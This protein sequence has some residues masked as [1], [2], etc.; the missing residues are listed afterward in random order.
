MFSTFVGSVTPDY[1]IT[2]LILLTV[3]LVLQMKLSEHLHQFNYLLLCLIISWALS[4]KLT[5]IL[6]LPLLIVDFNMHFRD[7]R[8]LFTGAGIFL[9]YL[10]PWIAGN[11][12][13]C[14][15][16]AYPINKI[17]LFSVDW[18]VPGFYFDYD[19]IVLR[20]WGRV[21]GMNVFESSNLELSQWLPLWFGR[22]DF[23]HKGLFALFPLSCITMV[24]IAWRKRYLFWPF[25]V[26]LAGFVSFFINGPH[27]RFLYGYSIGMLAL[28]AGALLYTRSLKIST[29]VFLGFLVVGTCFVAYKAWSGNKLQQT[30]LHPAPYP[31]ANVKLKY[32]SGKPFYITRLNN[33]CWDKFPSSY[34]FIYN[35]ELRG[36]QVDDGFRIKR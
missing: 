15:Y 34:Y 27:I 36:T 6:L 25:I 23:F 1:V 18:K 13:A 28:A 21:S 7:R 2:L 9:L 24:F 17:D 26:L 5:A 31:D 29:T 20:G 11:V 14:G 32:I 22:L 8:L 12:I 16:L 30:W 35:I 33:A 19:R 4:I 10:I 3:D